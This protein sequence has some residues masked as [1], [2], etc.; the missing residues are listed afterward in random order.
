MYLNN[1]LISVLKNNQANA[2]LYELRVVKL[3]NRYTPK[4]FSMTIIF[5]TFKFKYLSLKLM[6]VSATKTIIIP[7]PR[8]SLIYKKDQNILIN[9]KIF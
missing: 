6:C 1:I 5:M 3:K 7:T 4:R 9:N 8:Y 2:I